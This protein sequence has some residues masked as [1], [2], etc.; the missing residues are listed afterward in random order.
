M[1]YTCN[2]RSEA[3]G[4]SNAQVLDGLAKKRSILE[5][6]IKNLSLAVEFVMYEWVRQC[7]LAVK[8]VKSE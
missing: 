5:I 3:K 1:K 4:S 7:Y 6:V 2:L 8:G